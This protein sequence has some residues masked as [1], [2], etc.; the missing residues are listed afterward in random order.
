MGR[1]ISLG[2]VG[3]IDFLRSYM[4]TERHGV[5]WYI[6]GNCQGIW[7]HTQG[8]NCTLIHSCELIQFANFCSAAKP[9]WMGLNRI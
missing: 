6:C 1:D 8:E 5:E 3:E 9:V 4:Y 7:A 2:E